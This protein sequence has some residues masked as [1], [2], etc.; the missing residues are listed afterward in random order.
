[1]DALDPTLAAQLA[2]ALLQPPSGEPVKAAEPEPAKV[3]E[4][5]GDLDALRAELNELKSWRE[6]TIVERQLVDAK[7]DAGLLPVILAA[8]AADR[9]R[10]IRIL[11]DKVASLRAAP[12]PSGSAT[13]LPSDPAL[14]LLAAARAVLNH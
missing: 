6:R 8:P 12:P 13:E 2:A 10:A 11:S 4:P 5:H 14:R 9:E 7:L 1:M 3:A